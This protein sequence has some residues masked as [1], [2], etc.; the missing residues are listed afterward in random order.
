MPSQN[1][2]LQDDPR[3]AFASAN[4]ALAP[5]PT[6][7]DAAQWHAQNLA[8]TWAAAQNPQ[9]WVDAA[10]QYGNALMM[11]TTA[12]TAKLPTWYHGTSSRFDLFN[13]PEV[14]MTD[15][16][17][18]AAKYAEDVHRPFSKTGGEPVVIP[19]APKP[20]QVQ[21]IDEHLFDAM[22]DGTDLGDAIQEATDAARKGG[23]V[24]YLEYT[25]PNAGDQGD[26]TVRISLYPQEDLQ[27]TK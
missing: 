19:L 12:P 17:G 6:W 13:T 16:P 15:H 21:N 24:R 8:D 27:L 18:Q 4:N 26:H 5:Q 14:Y 10:R 1:P 11:G 23:K 9:T 3:Y 22:D 2:L 25:H 7:A 20:G